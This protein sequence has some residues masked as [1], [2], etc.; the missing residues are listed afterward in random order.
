MAAQ[1]S[2]NL[3]YD[4][5]DPAPIG[6]HAESRHFR[7]QRCAVAHQLG[8]PR[9]HIRSVGEQRT[10]LALAHSDKLL[11]DRGFEIDDHAPRA[12]GPTVFFEQDC[13]T[14]RRQHDA[15]TPRQLRDQLAFARP[16]TRL[17]LFLE[18][19]RYVD[20][21]ALLEFD[22]GIDERQLQGP[23]QLLAHRRFSRAH[24]PDQDDVL[25]AEVSP[26]HVGGQDYPKPDDR[27]DSASAIR[28]RRPPFR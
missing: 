7:I 23:R 17:A 13:P 21:G 22:V 20:A 27:S 19:E 16:K 26:T 2:E 3:L 9:P 5:A 8:K 14:T 6:T 4:V 12:Q 28:H 15:I 25:H 18:D 11:C 24:R 10:V 1:V